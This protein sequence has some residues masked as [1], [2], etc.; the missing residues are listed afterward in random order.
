MLNI[1]IVKKEKKKK[2]EAKLYGQSM[3]FIVLLFN[4]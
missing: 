3:F 1:L 2:N 4:F